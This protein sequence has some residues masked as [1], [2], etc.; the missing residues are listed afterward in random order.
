MRLDPRGNIVADEF[1]ATSA[2]GVYAVGDVLGGPQFTHTSW[3]DHRRLFD[4]LMKPE[5]PA[6]ARSARLVPYS[7]FTDPQVAAV[8]LNERSAKGRGIPYQVADHADRP[9]WRG[10][11]RST[12]RPV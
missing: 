6:S 3:D 4:I 11:S 12:R 1:Y 8:G 5:P 7:V 10:P 9:T 2:P